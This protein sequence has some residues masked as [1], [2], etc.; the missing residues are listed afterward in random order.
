MI[1][2]VKAIEI[3]LKD[4]LQKTI[5][6]SLIRILEGLYKE[7]VNRIKKLTLTGNKIINEKNLAINP[8][9]IIGGSIESFKS[10][11]EF[12]AEYSEKKYEV[13]GTEEVENKRDWWEFWRW[14]EPSTKTIS[15]YGD[16]EY[17]NM[18]DFL[19]LYHNDIE[20][21]VFKTTD[22][23]LQYGK[24]E[25]SKVEKQ[26][27]KTK[28]QLDSILKNKLEYI[29]E[30]LQ[31]KEKT[32]ERIKIKSEMYAKK[33]EWLKNIKNRIENVIEI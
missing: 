19:D 25:I 10:F 21:L 12:R 32:S 26:F 23:A 13:I 22:E 5:Q 24:K 20:S 30:L 1:K 6:E 29:S 11:D 8:F 17:V 2:D 4:E 28:E 18:E 7:Y 9:E 27:I 14:F 15:V 31:N 3:E 16:V 33:I